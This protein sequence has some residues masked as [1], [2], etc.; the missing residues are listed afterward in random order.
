M[1]AHSQP[2]ADTSDGP[3][4][5]LLVEDNPGD[6]RLIQEAFKETEIEQ[7]HQVFTNG[8]DALD[9]LLESNECSPPDLVFLDL[10]LPGKDGC[11]ILETIRDDSQLER[12]PVIIL[13]SSEDS[14]DVERCYRAN[15]NAYLTKPTDLDELVSV[16]KSVEQFWAE[17]VQ[18]PL[19]SR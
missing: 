14:D 11:E 8:E 9:F 13:T 2:S 10:N 6:V 5:I 15:A 7:T 19:I 3:V 12:L 16:V 1:S 4:D 18:L 17:H